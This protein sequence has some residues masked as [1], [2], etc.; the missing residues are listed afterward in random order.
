MVYELDGDIQLQSDLISLSG[1]AKHAK[2]LARRLTSGEIQ[3]MK[4]NLQRVAFDDAVQ[5]ALF[6]AKVNQSDGSK[7]EEEADDSEDE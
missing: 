5:D 7:D 4:F 3:V 6:K 1:A 2:E